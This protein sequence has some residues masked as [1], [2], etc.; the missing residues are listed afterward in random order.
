MG[1]RVFMGIR[2]ICIYCLNQDF[3]KIFLDL[4][5]YFRRG[6]ARNAPTTATSLQ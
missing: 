2:L 6:V 4:Q 1:Q 5:K 3:N